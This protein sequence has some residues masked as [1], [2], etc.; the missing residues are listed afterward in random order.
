[1]TNLSTETLE[2][3]LE[4]EKQTTPEPWQVGNL[5]SWH[6]DT[7]EPF[8]NVWSGEGDE[9]KKV[10]E[11]QGGLCDVNAKLTVQ[12]RTIAPQAVRELIEARELLKQSN[13]YLDHYRYELEQRGGISETLNNI[14]KDNKQYLGE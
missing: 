13:D 11:F 4:L 8:R 3:F 14:I 2:K 1:V 10:A 12:S 5:V 9:A 7:G 6:G